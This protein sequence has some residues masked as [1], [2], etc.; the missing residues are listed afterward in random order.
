MCHQRLAYIQYSRYVYETPNLS[1]FCTFLYCPQIG[2]FEPTVHL[3]SRSPPRQPPHMEPP[4]QQIVG[5]F[6]VIALL[7][8]VLRTPSLFGA[9]C[10]GCLLTPLLVTVVPPQQSNT[11]VAPLGALPELAPRPFDAQAWLGHFADPAVALGGALMLLVEGLRAAAGILSP[12]DERAANWFLLN[13]GVIHTMMDGLTG[14]YHFLP[15]MDENYRRLDNRAN[16]VLVDGLAKTGGT[17]GL[18]D[19]AV[20]VAMVSVT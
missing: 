2:E 4:Q 13:G 1:P 10:L 18:T 17:P 7:R 12:G 14:G 11:S 16:G 19:D 20:A 15:L 3:S 5:T 9:F 6:S 8:T